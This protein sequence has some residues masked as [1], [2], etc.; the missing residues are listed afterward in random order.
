VHG[1]GQN[2]DATGIFSAA[3]LNRLKDCGSYKNSGERQTFGALPANWEEVTNPYTKERMYY[4][5][6][7][8]R[9]TSIMRPSAGPDS[10]L[11]CNDWAGRRTKRIVTT[12]NS[13]KINMH[14]TYK[15]HRCYSSSEGDERKCVCECL[16]SPDYEGADSTGKVF[17]DRHQMG[18]VQGNAAGIPLDAGFEWGGHTTTNGHKGKMEGQKVY[19]TLDSAYKL[20]EEGSTYEQYPYQG[21]DIFNAAGGL[22][23]T[24]YPTPSPKP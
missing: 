10:P 23:A 11:H 2:F 3:R 16:D 21:Q 8:T 15:K 13:L 14:D 19:S 24:P 4:W 1:H 6:T 22:M 5:N 17:T 9:E 12:H 7:V 20:P 18:T